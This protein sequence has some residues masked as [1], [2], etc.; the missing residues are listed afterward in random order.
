MKKQALLL[1]L[2]LLVGAASCNAQIAANCRGTYKASLDAEGLLS[3]LAAAPT[4]SNLVTSYTV[5]HTGTPGDG[6]DFVKETQ[7]KILE[8]IDAASSKGFALHS[9]DLSLQTHA[10]DIITLKANSL[11]NANPMT[12][13]TEVLYQWRDSDVTPIA[14][15]GYR[16]QAADG[17]TLTL[18]R[19]SP[20]TLRIPELHLILTAQSK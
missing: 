15:G 4:D 2:L 5:T 6:T 18:E 17:S 9:A 16:I 14:N 8:I 20:T 10:Y 1:S 3:S 13:Q 19:L 11:E 12:K 7:S